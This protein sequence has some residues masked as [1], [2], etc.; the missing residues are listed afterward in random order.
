MKRATLD[1]L[2]TARTHPA[3]GGAETHEDVLMR[4]IGVVFCLAM[5]A[6]C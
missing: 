2:R 6:R 3:G 5:A 1:A 4:R